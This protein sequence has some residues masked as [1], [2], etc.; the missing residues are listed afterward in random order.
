[1]LDPP[2]FTPRRK[3]LRPAGSLNTSPSME[4][5]SSQISGEHEKLL[6]STDIQ[7]SGILFVQFAKRGDTILA[8]PSNKTATV[9]KTMSVMLISFM[10]TIFPIHQ[11]I[12]NRTNNAHASNSSKC[13]YRQQMK[14]WNGI[15]QNHG[16]MLHL[17]CNEQKK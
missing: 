4:S 15:K 8:A 1:L 10:D 6:Q 13:R 11:I 3:T 5:S 12:E 7:W 17:Q 9:K 2:K 14:N 16:F